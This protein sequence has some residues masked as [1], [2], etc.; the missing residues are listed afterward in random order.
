M[1]RISIVVLILC[2]FVSVA[3][4]QPLSCQHPSAWDEFHRQNMQRSNPCENVLNVGN[5]GSLVLKW[6]YTT[7]TG[8]ESSP[9]VVDG[10]VYVG[11]NNGNVYALNASIGALLWSYITRGFVAGSPALSNGV[12]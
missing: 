8:V 11:S 4:G 7:V 9:A 2:G 10:V 6:T 12:V 1:K 3:W 5:V